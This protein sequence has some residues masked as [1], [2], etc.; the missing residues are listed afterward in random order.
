MQEFQS[1]EEYKSQVAD[2]KRSME[3]QGQELLKRAFKEFFVQNLEIH[4][5]RWRQYTP[6]FNDGEP[7]RFGILDFE[8]ALVEDLKVEATAKEPDED[9]NEEDLKFDWYDSDALRKFERSI[10]D[11]ELFETVFGD[12]VEVTA[13]RDGFKVK[14]YISHE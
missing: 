13:T 5:I 12:G 14:D 6:Y 7:C 11:N 9:E 8:V 3:A 1:I 10:T 4:A 2:L